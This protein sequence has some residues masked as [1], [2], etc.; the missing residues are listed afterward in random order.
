MSLTP[1]ALALLSLCAWP[2]LLVLIMA[3]HRA[4]YV[5]TGKMPVN[6]F[7]A[8]GS[9]T[10]DAFGKRLVRAHAN[11][12]ENLPMQAG[13]LLFAIATQQ[14]ALTDPLAWAMLA[15]RVLQSVVHMTSTSAAAVWLRFAA[16]GVQVAIALYWLGLLSGLLA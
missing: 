5:F 14:T 9:N 16:Y 3:N 4:F 1:S 15:A 10:P 6:G 8:D 2:L 12:Y 13:I 11:C 7:A